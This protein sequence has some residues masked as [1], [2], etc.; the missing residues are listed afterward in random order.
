MQM[1]AR[2]ELT[3]EFNSLSLNED[4]TVTRYSMH[5]SP[6]IPDDRKSLDGLS[7]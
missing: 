2:Y 3:L 4:A 6:I 7:P 5:N 1:R